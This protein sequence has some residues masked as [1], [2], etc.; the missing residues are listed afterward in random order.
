MYK[1]LFQQTFIYGLATV[2]PRMFSFILVPL[3]TQVLPVAAYGEVSVIFSYIVLFNVLLSYGME[4]SFFRFYTQ[5]DDKEKVLST[6][7]I[8]VLATSVLF[9]VVGLFYRNSL[10][11]WSLFSVENISYTIWIV[12][13]DALVFIPFSKLRVDQRPIFY[14]V[15]KIVNVAINLGLNVFFLVLFPVI[16]KANPDSVMASF[17]VEDFEI[18]YIFMSNVVASLFTFIVL[19]PH[20]FKS[21]WQFDFKLW[22][23]MINYSYPVL[24]AGVAFAINETFDRILLDKLLPPAESLQAVG[25]Y[26]ACYK[27]ALFITLFATAFRLGVEPFFFSQA[28]EKN[29]PQT[30]ATITKYYIIFGSVIVLGVVVFVD[31]LKVILIRNETYWEAMKIV[32]LILFANLFLGI[33]H[34]LSV[35]YKL[36]DKTKMGAYISIIGALI[37]LG[38]NFYLIP[39]IGYYGSAIATVT[40]YGT[41]M[42][43]SF[44]FSKKYYP[45][46]YE[47]KTILMY[48]LLTISFSLVSFYIFAHNLYVGLL[49]LAI[50]V[51]FVFTKEKEIIFKILKKK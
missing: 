47:V 33:Y 18:G 23:K 5:E 36:T 7:L 6:S 11:D 25:A 10:S 19:S 37:T 48:L 31:V 15:L 12:T 51:F 50:Y 41:M 34:N 9:L 3:Y 29:A 44:L 43:I 24:I 22:A 27:L 40:A 16:Y 14:A 8:S 17:Y 32:P 1:K 2:L 38:L 26:S 21:K 42:I 28:K 35:W 49:L 46:P 45:I 39:N 4:T 13:L 20:Y 30:Y